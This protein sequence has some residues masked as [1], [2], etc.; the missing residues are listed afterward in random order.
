MGITADIGDVVDVSSRQSQNWREQ[1]VKRLT[2][3][4]QKGDGGKRCAAKTKKAR[5]GEERADA[6]L[7]EEEDGGTV[8]LVEEAA[9]EEEV[10]DVEGEEEGNFRGEDEE[11]GVRTLGVRR[12]RR[13]GTSLRRLRKWR[14][15]RK[16]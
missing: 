6:R 14:T 16:Y 12:E 10:E 11:G 2:D 7:V 5:E 13:R 8:G 1:D 15:L 9:D 3:A 4:E